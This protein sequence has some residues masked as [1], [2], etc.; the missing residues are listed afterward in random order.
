MTKRLPWIEAIWNTIRC[1][2]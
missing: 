1:S 2:T